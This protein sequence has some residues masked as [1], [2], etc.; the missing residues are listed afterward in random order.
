MS[1][2]RDVL[3]TVPGFKLFEAAAA[4]LGNRSG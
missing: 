1:E 2:A 3:T 4:S